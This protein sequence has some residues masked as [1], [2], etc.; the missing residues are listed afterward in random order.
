MIFRRLSSE[1][2]TILE[3]D[4][5]SQVPGSNHISAS[6]PLQP[7]APIASPEQVF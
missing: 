1:Q 6:S 7:P 3:T 2:A 5:L 4:R